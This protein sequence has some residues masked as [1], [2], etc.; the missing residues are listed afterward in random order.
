MK[1]ILLFLISFYCC[2]LKAGMYINDNSTSK[3]IWRT[4]IGN[5]VAIGATPNIF[6]LTLQSV[7]IFNG[8]FFY[9]FQ[10]LKSEKV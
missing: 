1:N 6:K 2:E 5:T 8:T 3:D 4:T 7:Y 10:C 9:V